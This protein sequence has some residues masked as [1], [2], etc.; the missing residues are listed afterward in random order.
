VSGPIRVRLQWRTAEQKTGSKRHFLA[1][2]WAGEMD[3]KFS[4]ATL[5]DDIRDSTMFAF[6]QHQDAIDE[7]VKVTAVRHLQQLNTHRNARAHN[8][9]TLKID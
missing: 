7:S 6:N 2:R 8:N 3:Q 9:F 1:F 5:S 4:D